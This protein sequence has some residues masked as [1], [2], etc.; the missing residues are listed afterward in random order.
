MFISRRFAGYYA[1]ESTVERRN[2]LRLPYIGTYL[3]ACASVVRLLVGPNQ[4]LSRAHH[5]KFGQFLDQ[6]VGVFHIMH[7]VMYGARVAQPNSSS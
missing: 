1:F 2:D 4:P 6:C 7:N 5:D 3:A